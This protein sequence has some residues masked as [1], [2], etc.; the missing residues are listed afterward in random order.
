[1]NGAQ[2]LP[3]RLKWTLNDSKPIG[4]MPVDVPRAAECG[5]ACSPSDGVGARGGS[6]M[7]ADESGVAGTDQAVEHG[8]GALGSDTDCSDA[9]TIESARPVQG[10]ES[11]SG[12]GSPAAE[13]AEGENACISDT[14]GLQM[15]K[16][17]P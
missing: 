3:P 15:C 4:V 14:P 10:G 16:H 1:L 17:T 12:E 11:S 13:R 9:A 7:R 8:L 6:L 5:V 2:A